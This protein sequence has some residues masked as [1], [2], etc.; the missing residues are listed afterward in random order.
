MLQESISSPDPAVK[1][2][3]VRSLK[4]AII[5]NKAK[6]RKYL[7]EGALPRCHKPGQSRRVCSELISLVDL[8]VQGSDCDA[9]SGRERRVANPV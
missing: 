8:A 7:A 5:G 4:N 9:G 2:K 1:L 6:K 3:A